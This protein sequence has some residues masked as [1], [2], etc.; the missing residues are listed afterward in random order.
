MNFLHL[1]AIVGLTLGATARN[2]QCDGPYARTR[3][4]NDSLVVDPTGSY[5]NSFLNVSDATNAL[6]TSTTEE[7]VIFVFPGTYHEQVYVRFMDGPIIL[8]GYTCDSRSYRNNEVTLSQNKSRLSPGVKSNDD[9]VTLKLWATSGLKVYNLNVANTFGFAEENGQ[10][11]AVSA[12]TAL[13]GFYGCNFTG[14]QDTLYANEGRQLFVDS[15]ISGAVDF[16]FGDSS[17]AWFERID[18]ETVGP[19]Y[20][21]ANGRDSEENDSWY[22]FNRCRVTGTNEPNTT[23]LGRPWGPYSRVVFQN[24]YLGDV[25]NAKGWSPWNSQDSPNSTYY[26]EF[27]NSGPGTTGPR[28]TW[29][30]YL[31]QPVNIEDILGDGFKSEWWV[32]ASYLL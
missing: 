21:T 17:R 26:R 18:I 13:Q 15:F 11:L 29:A 3:P 10:A 2:C 24:S 22:I 31:D 14:Y 16:I 6:N 19:G 30:G 7:Q 20:I 12:E 5:P 4:P 28:A 27:N 9:T 8:Q 1:F 23:Y 32:D 25:I